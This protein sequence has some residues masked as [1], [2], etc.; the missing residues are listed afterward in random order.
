[1]F[2]LQKKHVTESIQI[3]SSKSEN[4]D[5]VF[6]KTEPDIHSYF[7]EVCKCVYLVKIYLKLTSK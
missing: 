2:F 1:M 3:S 6:I 4:V 7:E 5:T